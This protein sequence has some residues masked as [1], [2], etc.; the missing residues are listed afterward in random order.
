MSEER[1]KVEVVAADGTRERMV[2][3]EGESEAQATMRLHRLTG[4]SVLDCQRAVRAHPIDEDARV[5][6]LA[7]ML[8]AEGGV[9]SWRAP[10]WARP[11][12]DARLTAAGVPGDH[13]HRYVLIG[14]ALACIVC[15]RP[16][17]ITC[18][19][20]PDVDWDELDRVRAIVEDTILRAA[21][22]GD[23][24]GLHAAT[25][26]AFLA[27]RV[28]WALVPSVDVPMAD[29]TKAPPPEFGCDLAPPLPSGVQPDDYVLLLG[30][31]RGTWIRRDDGTW[32]LIV[33]ED[34]R[35]GDDERGATR[36]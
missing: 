36:A 29:E 7:E 35:R 2:V 31:S 26:A 23:L 6:A 17:G 27:E 30:G 8:H 32:E 20:F 11:W 33:D 14:A 5:G 4:M 9:G 34:A 3:T 25:A 18:V 1:F 16:G 19:A 15:G 21:A 13:E 24:P 22:S 12:M 28:A 10:E